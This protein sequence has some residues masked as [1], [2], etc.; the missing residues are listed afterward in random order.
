VPDRAADMRHNAICA[1]IRAT[2]R[3][4]H[5]CMALFVVK[6][7]WYMASGLCCPSVSQILRPKQADSGG[8]R[9]CAQ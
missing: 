3:Y 1:E 9:R 2:F 8:Y 7:V 4:D 6:P 5:V